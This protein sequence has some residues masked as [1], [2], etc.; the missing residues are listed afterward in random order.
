MVDIDRYY[1]IVELMP[2][3]S[4]NEMRQTYRDLTKVW[5]PDRFTNDML[6]INARNIRN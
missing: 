3:A 5:H 2:G 4:A 6:L 1:T